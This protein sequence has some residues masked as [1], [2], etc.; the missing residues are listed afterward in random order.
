MQWC[1]GRGGEG[2][3]PREGGGEREAVVRVEARETV[4]GGEVGGGRGARSFSK[5]VSWK[6]A[7]FQHRLAADGHAYPENVFGQ[8]LYDQ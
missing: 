6:S 4:C 3:G 8:N 7:K 2:R 5:S 1:S